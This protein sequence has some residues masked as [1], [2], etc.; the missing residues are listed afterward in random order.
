MGC[1]QEEGVDYGAT[2]TPTVKISTICLVLAIAARN[3]LELNVWDVV[4]TFLNPV[5]EQ[6][7]YMQQIPGFPLDDPSKVLL[8][9]KILYG[10]KQS[11]H[12]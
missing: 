8:L 3:D 4:S 9:L 10:L 7:I 2:F 6:E 12:E 5:L 11:S 1:E